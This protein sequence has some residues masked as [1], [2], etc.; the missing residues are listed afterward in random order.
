MTQLNVKFPPQLAE[1][2]FNEQVSFDAILH[3]PTIALTDSV[4]EAFEDFLS[5][6]DSNSTDE[7][8]KKHPQLNELIEFFK[9]GEN[10]PTESA[11]LLYRHFIYSDFE[12]EFLVQVQKPVPRNF[13]FTP[14]GKFQSC[15]IGGVYELN[16][17]FAKDMKHAAEQ[18]LEI[19]EKIFLEAETKAR[20]EQGI[21][22]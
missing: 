22:A 13:T 20:K 5:S 9:D 1:D 15:S 2:M 19:A 10:H 6:M 3:I 8:I 7:I 4:P 17:I 18:A 12:F 14:E 11:S 16:W 21:E